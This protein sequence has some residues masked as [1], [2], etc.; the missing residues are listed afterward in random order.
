MCY[1]FAFLR[2]TYIGCM[3]YY[4]CCFPPFLEGSFCKI[5]MYYMFFRLIF[6]NRVRWQATKPR[7]KPVTMRFFSFL[8][9]KVADEKLGSRRTPEKKNLSRK[10]RGRWRTIQASRERHGCPRKGGII[11]PY[12]YGAERLIYTPDGSVLP[13]PF[14]RKKHLFTFIFLSDEQNACSPQCSHNTGVVFS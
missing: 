14:Y 4:I 3:W 6:K 10:N 5:S 12:L 11:C 8:G 9:N 2:C 13:L 1:I 7:K